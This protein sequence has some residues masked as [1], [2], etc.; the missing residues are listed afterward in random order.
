MK[1]VLDPVNDAAKVRFNTIV[2]VFPA[3]ETEDPVPFR[4]H[5]LFWAVPLDP[6]GTAVVPVA[7]SLYK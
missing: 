1:M 5:W 3:P 7:E 6:T 2:N 4:V